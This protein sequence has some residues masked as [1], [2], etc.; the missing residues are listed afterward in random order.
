MYFEWNWPTIW[1]FK[2]QVQLFDISCYFTH[3]GDHAP[4]FHFSLVIC[5]IKL[6]DF[7]YYNT[8]HEDAW[9]ED[10]RYAIVGDTRIPSDQFEYALWTSKNEPK[11]GEE[12]Y[13]DMMYFTAEAAL[14][15]ATSAGIKKPRIVSMVTRQVWETYQ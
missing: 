11:H 1:P 5:N 14:L 12:F 2:S 6:F 4:G 8:H 3:K 7:G 13:P 9:E 10:K 15:F